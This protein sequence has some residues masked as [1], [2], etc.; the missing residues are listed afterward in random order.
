M[1]D[2]DQTNVGTQFLASTALIASTS[3]LCI[4]I[5]ALMTSKRPLMQC[6]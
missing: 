1:P 2:R 4:G 6:L 3:Y 5:F